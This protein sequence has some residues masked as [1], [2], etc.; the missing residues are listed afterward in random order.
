MTIESERD[1]QIKNLAK[2]LRASGMASS[3]SQALE[4]ARSMISTSKKVQEGYNGQPNNEDKGYD[5]ETA[6]ARHEEAMPNPDS[7]SFESGKIDGQKLYEQQQDIISSSNNSSN[8]SAVLNSDKPIA[9]LVSD[10]SVVSDEGSLNLDSEPVETVVE[11]EPIHYEAEP[12]PESEVVSEP[13]S[14]EPEACE[15]ETKSECESCDSES[16]ESE[17]KSESESD[18]EEG[19]QPKPGAEKMPESTIDLGEVFKFG[20]VR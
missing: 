14:C 7:G 19:G 20:N 17:E 2:T 15:S 5:I 1:E 12:E 4:M 11:P 3:D 13:D 9:D 8:N 6:K 10:D 18:Q 16:S